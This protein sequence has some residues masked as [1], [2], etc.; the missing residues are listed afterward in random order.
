VRAN[1][2]VKFAPYKGMPKILNS[3]LIAA[4]LSTPGFAQVAAPRY[5]NF[6][7]E[8]LF[9]KLKTDQQVAELVKQ[10]G[11]NPAADRFRAALPWGTM[12][13]WFTISDDGTN[14]VFYAGIREVTNVELQRTSELFLKLA[15]G[16]GRHQFNSGLRIVQIGQDKPM[17]VMFVQIPNHGATPADITGA[18]RQLN[19][20]GKKL[21][22]RG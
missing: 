18:I 9:P 17:M 16:A 10:A 3:L 6:L 5:H 4:A 8:V 12:E 21:T 2:V 11:F 22:T 15:A 13:V 14:L 20:S 7:D 1:L 19:G